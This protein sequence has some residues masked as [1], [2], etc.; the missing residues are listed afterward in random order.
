MLEILVHCISNKQRCHNHSAQ[1]QSTR[2]DAT[3][4]G[5]RIILVEQINSLRIW[6][7]DINGDYSDALFLLITC[8]GV[9]L[10]GNR[11]IK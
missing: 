4:N 7:Y 2:G 5:T 9:R 3:D 11:L 1:C 8:D 6:K 10:K